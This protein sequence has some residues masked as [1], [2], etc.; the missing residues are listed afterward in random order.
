DASKKTA[1]AAQ[2]IAIATEEIANGATSLAVEA[3]KGSDLTSSINSQMKNVID[4]NEQ[5]VKSALDVEKASEQGTSYMGIL[6]EKTGA[7]EEMTRSMVE[8]VDALKESTS[9]IVKILDV[10]NSV[11]K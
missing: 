11:A 9:S 10:L 8:K 5:M 3:E 2:E 7:T 4:A 1:I 6:I